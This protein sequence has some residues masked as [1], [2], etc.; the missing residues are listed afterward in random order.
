MTNCPQLFLAAVLLLCVLASCGDAA[1]NASLEQ[2]WL[3]VEPSVFPYNHMSTIAQINTTYFVAAWQASHLGEGHEDQ[4]ILVSI[5]TNG[6]QNWTYPRDMLPNPELIPF[7]GPALFWHRGQQRLY[8][9]Y[10]RS[11]NATARGPGRYHPGGSIFVTHSDDHGASWHTGRELLDFFSPTRGNIAKVTANKPIFVDGTLDKW[12]IPFWQQTEASK[13]HPSMNTTGP[14]CASLLMT[15]DGGATYQP[16]GFIHSVNYTFYTIEPSAILTDGT[17]SGTV[18]QYFRTENVGLIYQSV[19]RDYGKTW[20]PIQ[21]TKLLNPDS[22]VYLSSRVDFATNKTVSAAVAYNPTLPTSPNSNHVLVLSYTRRPELLNETHGSDAWGKD[23][24]LVFA[25]NSVTGQSSY[26]P[27]LIPV[28][29]PGEGKDGGVREHWMCTY[30][31]ETVDHHLGIR[32]AFVKIED[33][34]ERL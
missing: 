18:L 9:Y 12:I 2:H 6:G 20:S 29:G 19:S 31:H 28:D 26:Y 5:S 14:P 13:H 24:I 16:H 25:N 7:W 32:I 30:T 4:R 8:C 21:P 27:T 15:T 1:P 17:N 11:N 22:K 33:H 23:P 3:F 10:S 34:V